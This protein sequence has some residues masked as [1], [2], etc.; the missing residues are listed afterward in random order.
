MKKQFGKKKNQFA[1]AGQ[2]KHTTE[3]RAGELYLSDGVG[4]ELPAM[5]TLLCHGG[6]YRR[7]V[8]ATELE[9]FLPL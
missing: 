6:V 4:Q 2:T 7:R 5:S 1:I 9:T 3:A 8:E